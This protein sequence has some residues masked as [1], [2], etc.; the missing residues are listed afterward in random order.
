MSGPSAFFLAHAARVRTAARRGPVVDLACG[1]GRHCLAAAAAGAHAVGLDRN[2]ES[3]A[4]LR[5]AARL[6]RLPVDCVRADLERDPDLPLRAGSCAVILVFRFLYRPLA[7]RIERA[8]QP[9]GLLLYETFTRD[10]AELA[11]GPSN[12]AFLLERGELPRLFPNLEALEHWEGRTAGDRPT[13][14]ARLAARKPG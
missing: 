5:D 2:G 7:A 14:V 4:D 8:L 9:G 1:R 10:Q 12:P 3:L 11:G 6:R 13:A